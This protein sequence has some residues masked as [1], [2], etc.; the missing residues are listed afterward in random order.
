MS[1]KYGILTI[2]WNGKHHGYDLK[3]G[4]DSLIGMKGKIN[5]GQIYTTLDRLS[6]DGMVSSA[7]TDNQE[8]KRYAIE[9]KGKEA[10]EKWLLDPVPYHSTKEDFFYKWNCARNIQFDEEKQMLDQQKTLII[11][12]T[13]E[14]SKLKT[15]FLIKGEEDKYLLVTGTLLHLEADLNWITRVENRLQ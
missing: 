4:V 10:L 14:L 11:K 12:E 8:R 13:L 15:E 1:V 9:E 7:G 3:V 5:P 2:L 6:R